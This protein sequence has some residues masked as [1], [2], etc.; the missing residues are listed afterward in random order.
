MFLILCGSVNISHTIIITDIRFLPTIELFFKLQD[1]Y[2]TLLYF[3]RLKLQNLLLEA[4]LHLHRF[5]VILREL[6]F[7]CV[8]VGL[9]YLT[10][11]MCG[12]LLACIMWRIQSNPEV[13]GTQS[14]YILSVG[15]SGLYV[16]SCLTVVTASHTIARKN[17]CQISCWSSEQGPTLYTLADTA[18]MLVIDINLKFSTITG[19][20]F[21][22]NFGI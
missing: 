15:R 6:V 3:F 16:R 10:R 9:K 4:F 13:H 8:Y 7:L 14:C 1:Y 12:E 18:D 21:E 20:E 5:L 11:C 2:C 22:F 17:I 19:R